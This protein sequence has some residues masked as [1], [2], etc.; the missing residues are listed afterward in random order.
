ML[1]PSFLMRR[2]GSAWVLVGCLMLSVLITTA[3][4]TAL[5]SFYSAALPATVV[6][7]LT[8]SGALS[9]T[10]NDQVAGS[11]AGTTRLVSTKM[12]AAFGPHVPYQVYQATWSNDL[13]LPGAHTG[14]N[15]PVLQ[16]AAIDDLSAH[17]DLTSGHWPTAPLAGQPVPV[18][19]PVNVA[20]D[21]HVAVGSVL[22]LRYLASGAPASLQVTGLFRPR[23]AG[24]AYWRL[25]VISLSGVTVGSGFASYGPAVASPAA[26]GPA[27]P[28]RPAAL[29]PN[30]ASF[31]VVPQ[32]RAIATVDL[33]GLAARLDQAI[34]T[35]Q[36]AGVSLVSTTM[37]QT[38]ID[39]A[40]GLAAARA[41]VLISGLQLLLLAAAALALAGRLLASQRDE[42]TALLAARGAA[43][44]QLIRPS[45]T[46]GL[47]ACAAAAAIGAIAGVR[48]ADML[49][50]S[51]GG[52]GLRQ[53]ALRQE[54]W[55]GAAAVLIFCL[56][57]AL[58]PAL[59]PAG[60]GAVR[61]R[62]GRQAAVASAAAA[63][64][65]IAVIALA[66]VSVH[67]L[68][69]YKAA[70][71]SG[72]NLV[73][74]AA[75]MLALAGLALIPLRLLPL[76]A[77]GLERLTA[78][79]RRLGTA[80]ANW[81]ISRRP[82]RQS[83]PALLVIL[84]VGTSTLAL[85]QYRSWQQSIRDQAA[86]QAGAQVRVGLA[87]AEPL[88]GVAQISR[89]R[90]VTA[91]M[92]ASLQSISP[93]QLLA[94]GG[95][96]AAATVT[97]RPDLSSQVPLSQLWGL[98]DQHQGRLEG[99][100]IPGR[101]ARLAIAASMAGGLAGQLGPVA[102]TM[103]VQDAYGLT[104]NLAAG[105]MAADGR[106]HQLIALVGAAAGVAYPLRLLS[107]SLTYN[108]P[109]APT[110][111]RARAAEATAVIKVSSIAISATPTGQ[112]AAPF[113]AGRTLA[114]WR[115]RTGAP[116]LAEISRLLAGKSY[117]SQQPHVQT[118]RVAG[119]D[120]ELTLAPGSGPVLPPSYPQGYLAK[121]GFAALP[122]Q[123][124]LSIAPPPLGVPLLA[125]QAYLRAS[126]LTNGS[127][128]PITIGGTSVRAYVLLTVAGFPTITAAGAVI[129]DQTNLQDALVAAG[130]APLAATSWWLSTADGRPPPGLPPGSSVIDAAAITQELQ[131]NPE[132]A[133]PIKAALAVAAAAA[134]LAALGFCVSVA[135]SARSRRGQRALLAAL[136]VPSGAQARLFC[137][138]EIMISGPAA[139]VGLALGIGLARLL[140]PAITL[141]ATAGVPV[142]PVLV[143]LPLAWV[144]FIA[145]AVPAIPV[146]AAAITALR[147]PDP[148]AELRI[149]EAGG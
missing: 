2:M 48:L 63:G 37:P 3:L 58:W 121:N 131:R 147:Q 133:A 21:L 86:F 137:L 64:A 36:N 75:P 41:L 27:G 99:L 53:A 128:V 55:L 22:K 100:P 106:P 26:F 66:L 94:I 89:L 56:G 39:V 112:F 120:A 29:Q 25:D 87:N 34:G 17:A 82:V 146:L 71:G 81:E 5:L 32:A 88:A 127:P 126:G 33:D 79:S 108:M 73:I 134:V 111:A 124:T 140:I 59:R 84:A 20:A 143:R 114:G 107:V 13:G 12:R 145:I 139:L 28:G 74:A 9:I 132:S 47:L 23:E 50:S 103:I 101:P 4:V 138:E 141:T 144:V 115:P 52:P 72:T 15:V 61:I 38:L 69:T 18:A 116:G 68:L 60:I 135:A 14:G 95:P 109:L 105:A 16:A 78:R 118:W 85:A 110:S 65:D 119:Q 10:I 11:L 62:R 42:E 104:Y 70:S 40:E 46:E 67:E 24:A 102:A 49:L 31:E 96:Q 44:W 148:A 77:K 83:G 142:P 76:A 51:L 125:T 91:A 97:M 1:R 7:Q 57:I 80:M 93:G 113:A 92:P 123:V 130:G 43:R 54:A 30:V 45:L 19:L 149:A 129:A 136:G 8:R 35:L 122:A 6:R 90:G 98:L 117:N